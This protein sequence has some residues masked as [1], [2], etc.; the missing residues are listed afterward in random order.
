MKRK[1]TVSL[2]YEIEADAP[3]D[4]IRAKERLKNTFS[5]SNGRLESGSCSGTTNYRMKCLDRQPEMKEIGN[6]G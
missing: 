6:N 5:V 2:T 1:I 4:F 3:E